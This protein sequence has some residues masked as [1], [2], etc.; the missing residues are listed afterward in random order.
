MDD[1]Y[2]TGMTPPPAFENAGPSQE[3]SQVAL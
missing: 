1:Q 2:Q 3:L